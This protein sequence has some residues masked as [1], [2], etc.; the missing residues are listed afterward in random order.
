MSTDERF[1]GKKIPTSEFGADDGDVDP[2]V[3]TALREYAGKRLGRRELLSALSQSRVFVPVK[4]IL[5]S[6]EVDD[7]GHQVEKDSHMATV[8]MQT[9]DGRRGLLA[10]T[11]IASF[12]DWDADSRPV[13]AR[14][15][16]AA[17]AA[18]DEGADALVIDV[19]QGHRIALVADELVALA[20]G[21]SFETPATDRAI[22]QAVS[23]AVSGIGARYNCQ[24]QLTPPVG[25]G[26]IRINLIAKSDL[27]PVQVLNEVAAALQTDDYLRAVLVDGVEL[28]VATGE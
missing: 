9:A 21:S 19:T 25:K 28:G 26:A 27:D 7:Q 5:D 17:A 4:A 24:F 14:I 11:S 15:R 12:N 3:R 2:A 10:F 6:S 23:A 20:D 8:S 13:P 18:I 1:V 16:Q 22:A